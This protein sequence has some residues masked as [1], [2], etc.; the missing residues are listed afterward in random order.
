MEQV[1]GGDL[2]VNRGT[3]SKPKE[4]GSETTRDLNTVEGLDAAYKLAEVVSALT[5]L[6]R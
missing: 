4:S 2:V 6:L 1:E 5:F 3:E